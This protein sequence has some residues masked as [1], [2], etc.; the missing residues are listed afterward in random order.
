MR[1]GDGPLELLDPAVQNDQEAVDELALPYKHSRTDERYQ[2][3]LVLVK[4][5]RGEELD[6][7]LDL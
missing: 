7:L 5:D 4:F 3:S 1:V 6:K 2:R